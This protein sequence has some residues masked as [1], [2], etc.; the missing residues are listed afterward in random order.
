MKSYRYLSKI[1]ILNKSFTLKILSVTFIGIHIPLFAIIGYLLTIQMP[2][3]DALHIGI[4]TLC[5][6]LLSTILTLIL[7]NKL[8]K[9][10]IL[11]KNSLNNY[12]KYSK[13][14]KLPKNYIDEVGILLHD[15]QIGVEALEKYKEEH[16]ILL[17]LVNHDLKSP[18]T[19]TLGTLSLF[20]EENKDNTLIDAL[21]QKLNKYS[22]GLTQSI[23]YIKLQKNIIGTGQLLTPT[24]ISELIKN[25]I[26]AFQ[27]EANSKNVSF[28]LNLVNIDLEIPLTILERTLQNLL[29][30]AIKYT[31][32]DSIITITSSIVNDVLE[33]SIKDQGKGIAEGKIAE[34]FDYNRT[35]VDVKNHL[36][37]SNGIGLHLCKKLINNVG[38]DIR[39]EN[40]KDGIGATFTIQYFNDVP[41]F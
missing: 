14:P 20:R 37:N 26:V 10:I 7:L 25:T 13:K 11:V 2:V 19:S 30:N 24:N 28:Q 22:E 27:Y 9:P 21:E 16:E 18:I 36:S 40:N 41:V 17:N 32:N 6:T 35:L 15:V 5:F 3:E 4:L 29:S 31:L 38:G 8:L 33:I 23:N 34:I 39:V 12:I 1:P